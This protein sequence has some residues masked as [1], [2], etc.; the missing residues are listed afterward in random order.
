M[1]PHRLRI[2]HISDLHKRV[3]PDWMPAERGT[4]ARADDRGDEPL[5]RRKGVGFGLDECRFSIE[6]YKPGSYQRFE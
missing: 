1:P 5:V 4:K 6:I 2:L 3:A